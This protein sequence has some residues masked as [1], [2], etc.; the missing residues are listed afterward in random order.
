MAFRTRRETAAS[1][2]LLSTSLPLS[3]S[4]SVR[5]LVQER[6][7]PEERQCTTD[8]Y[9]ERSQNSKEKKLLLKYSS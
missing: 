5:H 1:E 8:P 3:F 4:V 6:E 7:G 9:K 2:N